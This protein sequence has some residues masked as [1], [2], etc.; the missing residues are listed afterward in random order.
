MVALRL[1]RLALVRRAE[2]PRRRHPWRMS[3]AVL[4]RK[5]ERRDLEAV[6][7]LGAMLI[8]THY[9]FDRKRF[10]APFDGADKS[11]ASFL[12]R[13]LDSPDQLVGLAEPDGVIARFHLS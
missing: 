11:Y 3:D 13:A 6:G 1:S 10:L 9:E 7:R 8:R 4:V 5:A 2:R 12:G